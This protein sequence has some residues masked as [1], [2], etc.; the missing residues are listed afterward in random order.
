M[1]NEVRPVTA[2]TS[3][4]LQTCYQF[5]TRFM[6]VNLVYRA[7]LW[8][9]LGFRFLFLLMQ[10]YLWRSLLQAGAAEGTTVD[11]MVTYVVLSQVIQA[12]IRSGAAEEIEKRLQSGDIALDLA[13]PVSYR[14]QLL[15]NNIGTSLSEIALNA[16]PILL[17]SALF[18]KVSPPLSPAHLGAF[19]LLLLGGLFISFYISYLIGLIA[20][21]FLRA[22]YLSWLVG[23]AQLFLAGGYIPLWFYPDWLRA[24][25]EAAPFKLMLYTPIAIYMGRIPLSEFGSA[26]LALLLWLAGLVVLESWLWRRTVH[27]LVVQGG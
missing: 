10:V 13:R 6:R 25:A 16:V 14:V 21:Y 24:I 8:I 1:I 20:F 12:F 4:S 9:R 11:D 19:L 5:A 2:K 27:R 15:M 18:L 26:L 7:N 3:A 23:T 17:A 22:E